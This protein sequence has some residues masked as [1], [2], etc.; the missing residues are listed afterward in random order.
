MFEGRNE[1][2]GKESGVEGEEGGDNEGGAGGGEEESSDVWELVGG[3]SRVDGV[4][5]KE[6]EVW[7]SVKEVEEVEKGKK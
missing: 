1:S 7:K 2:R 6:E 5:E 3:E 4:A